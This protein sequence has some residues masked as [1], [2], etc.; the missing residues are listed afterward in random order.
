MSSNIVQKQIYPFFWVYLMGEYYV[1]TV[2]LSKDS[3]SVII[4]MF[5]KFR[6]FR[7]YTAIL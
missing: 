7:N 4:K 5:L 6:E 2:Y 3:N 1:L